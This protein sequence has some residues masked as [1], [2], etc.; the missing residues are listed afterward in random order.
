VRAL[1][2]FRKEAKHWLREI[3]RNN[4]GPVKRLR[5]AYPGAPAAPGLR[6]IQHA[7][8]RE[9]GYESWK[10]LKVALEQQAPQYA[11]GLDDGPPHDHAGRVSRF[12]Q[13][14][15]WDGDAHGRALHGMK[16][17]AA[18]RLLQKY[19]EIARD[20]LYTAIVCGELQEVAR[21]LDEWPDLANRKGGSRRWEPLLYLCYARLPIDVTGDHS[22]AIARL[23]MDR[24]A[25]PNAYYMA[26]DAVYGTLVGVAGE[27]E[28]E[29]TPHPWREELYQL[30]LERGVEPFDIQVLY[31]T[32]FHGDVRWWLE[33]TYAHTVAAGNAAIWK[34]PDWPMLDM[35]G[36]GSGARFLF[37]IAIRKNDIALARWLVEHGANPNAAPAPAPHFS[38]VSLYEEAAHAGRPEIAEL[39]LRHGAT[40]VPVVLEGEDA[41]VAAC[42][43]Q[44]RAAAEAALARHPEYL[45]SPKALFAAARDD[46]ADVVTLLLDVG[47]PVDIHDQH[48]QRALHVAAASDARRVATLLIDRGADVDAVEKRFSATPLGF[49]S[50]HGRL[51]MIDL[52]AP[53]SRD[54]WNLTNL[55]KI[56]RLRAVLAEN[57][58]AARERDAGLTPLWWL[59]NDE[60]LAA[61][62][63]DLLL[64]HGADPTVKAKDGRTAADRARERGLDAAA[65]K[66]EAAR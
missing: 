29:A 58:A 42:L 31:N 66:L 19:P 28:Q 57:P 23:L 62:A 39:L 54:I 25:D 11:G 56:D 46:R 1:D 43:R 60:A 27:G 50:H 48:G 8:A 10:A 2:H 64:A 22:V 37:W 6:D 59:P 9:Q 32:H 44:D 49:A 7:L 4:P 13:L 53:V 47:T 20:T 52:L 38:K 12:L 30:L 24:G 45:Q 40:A 61:E 51:A 41:Y 21:I 18:A 35:G 14:A 55:G 34:D 15:C 36:Y 5:L 26:G 65:A 63:V 16:Q 3:G 17:A 33:L